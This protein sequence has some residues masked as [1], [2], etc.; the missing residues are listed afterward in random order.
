MTRF[1]LTLL[2]LGASAFVS[3]PSRITFVDATATAGIRF[4]HNSG[5]AGAKFL[6]ETLGSGVAIFDADGDGWPD[7]LFVNGR[8]WQLGRTRSTHALYR[9]A[10]DGTFRDVTRGSG[11]DVEMYGL[12]VAVGDYDNDGRSDVYI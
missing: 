8:D 2:A 1:A 11:L 3:P 5:R 10:G 4:V 7:L 6:P 9:N 12:G